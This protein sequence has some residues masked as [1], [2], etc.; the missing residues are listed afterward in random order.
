ML[1]AKVSWLLS[2][3]RLVSKI[4]NVMHFARL[5]EQASVDSVSNWYVFGDYM[6]HHPMWGWYC[7]SQWMFTWGPWRP[8]SLGYITDPARADHDWIAHFWGFCG[9][10]G[11]YVLSWPSIPVVTTYM[12]QETLTSHWVPCNHCELS[13]LMQLT[14][15]VSRHQFLAQMLEAKVSW[16][17]SRGRLVLL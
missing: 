12:S 11:S 6:V 17:L 13:S 5:V 9:F 8:G 1:E 4:D 7:Q 15:N 10:V 3:G 2:P 14:N 16:L